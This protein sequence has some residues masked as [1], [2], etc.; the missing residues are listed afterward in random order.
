MSD[1]QNPSTR[2]VTRGDQRA[3]I[4][5]AIGIV[6]ITILLVALLF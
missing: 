1:E 6:V 2:S 4:A 3:L 5:V